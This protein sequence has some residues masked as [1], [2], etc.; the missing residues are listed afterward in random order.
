MEMYKKE[1]VSALVTTNFLK[2]PLTNQKLHS[3]RRSNIKEGAGI[4][5]RC[6][7]AISKHINIYKK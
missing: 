1:D 3:R 6:L 4:I 7:F 2:G 5:V